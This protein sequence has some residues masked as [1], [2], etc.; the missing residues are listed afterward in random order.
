MLEVEITN[1]RQEIASLREAINGLTATLI[2]VSHAALPS[3]PEQ[4]SI[5]E[6][7]PAVVEEVASTPV[8]IDDLQA[9]CTELVRKDQNLKPKIKELINSFGGAKTLSKVPTDCL[10]KLKTALEA[11]Q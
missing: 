7:P 1:L 4:P 6:Q 5:S 2:G 9:L 10:P 8:T 11:I 3:I